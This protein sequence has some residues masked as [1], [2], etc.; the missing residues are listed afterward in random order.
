MLLL[1]GAMAFG[2]A[3]FDRNL[4][5]A[6]ALGVVMSILFVV[7]L[8]GYSTRERWRDL[9]VFEVVLRML[10]GFGLVMGV[11]CGC[12]AAFGIFALII[13]TSQRW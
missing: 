11:G 1:W 8:I 12:M 13:C 10:V 6:T 9:G 2:T 5:P 3:I 4:G 7:A